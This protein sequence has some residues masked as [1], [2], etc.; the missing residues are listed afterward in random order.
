MEQ[1]PRPDTIHYLKSTE[2]GGEVYAGRFKGD[3]FCLSEMKRD[4]LCPLH[5]RWDDLFGGRMNVNPAGAI[6]AGDDDD[7]DFAKGP[8]HGSVESCYWVE[9]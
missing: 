9:T 8:Q 4:E 1:K 6:K 2:Q 7:D 5:K 3:K